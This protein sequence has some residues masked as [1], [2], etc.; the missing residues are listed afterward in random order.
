VVRLAAIAICL[1]CAVALPTSTLAAPKHRVDG[2]LGEWRGKPTHIAGQT[3]TSRGELIYTDWLYDDHG[4]NLDG[5]PGQTQYRAQL[6]PRGGDYNYP[7]DADRYGYNAADLREL[8]VAATRRGLHFLIS[9]QTMKAPGAAIVGIALDGDRRRKT[10]REWPDGAGLT[11]KGAE[12]FVTVWGKRARYTGHKG[13][14]RKI[15][16]AVNLKQNAIEVFLPTKRAGRLARKPR[17]WVATGLHAGKGRFQA[18]RQGETAA[19][20]VGFREETYPRLGSAWNE[21]E[22]GIALNTGDVTRFSGSFDRR[23]LRRRGSVRVPP[24]APGFYNRVYRSKAGYGEGVELKRASGTSIGGSAAA[25]FKSP[26]QPYGLYVPEGWDPSQP[27][28]LTLDGHSLDGNMNQYAFVAPNQFAQLGDERGSLI[29]TPLARGSDTW[30]LDAG[31]RDTMDAWRDVRRHYRVDRERTAITGYSMGG[32]MTYRLGLL[33]PDRFSRA[34]VYVGPPAYQVWPYP[35][36]IVSGDPAWTVPGNTNQIVENAYNLPFEIV[37]G[38]ADELVPVSGVQQQADTFQAAGNEYRFYRHGA[39]D[40]LSFIFNDE[41]DRTRDWLGDFA[42]EKNPATVVYRRFPSM[43][44]PQHGYRFDRAYW[45]SEIDVREAPAPDS[46]GAVRATT[47]G[48]GGNRKQAQPQLPEAVSG[49]T[50]PGVLFSQKQVPG[51]EL[52]RSNRL[53]AELENLRSVTFDLERMGIDPS[54]P[55]TVK[56][57]TDGPAQ[58]VLAGPERRT[59]DFEAGTTEVTVEP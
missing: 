15:R 40:H 4:P 18:I 53:E 28:P 22:Q 44:L 56:V 31:F 23:K 45:A 48:L 35:A 47:F 25:Q 49:P 33:M 30:Y 24:L 7:D 38:N 52:P 10:T 9:L 14:S 50:T 57:T 26:W 12:R 1:L 43:D 37:H 39:D 20:N 46:S 2:R 36:P 41:W 11:A 3:T 19:F 13:R 8:R 16:S 32:Y 58:V 51:E 34:S 55:I 27:A 17:I 29:I 5:L 59:V 21:Q 54:A 6:M 42:R